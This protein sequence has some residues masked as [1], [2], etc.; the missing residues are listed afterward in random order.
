MFSR[1]PHARRALLLATTGGATAVLTS[2]P[3]PAFAAP[4][5]EIGDSDD[6]A[7]APAT[8]TPKYHVRA[9]PLFV[10]ALAHTSASPHHHP[11]AAN[12]TNTVLVVPGLLTANECDLLIAEADRLASL[13]LPSPECGSG[14]CGNC[15]GCLD[16]EDEEGEE[17]EEEGGDEG[18]DHLRRLSLCLM[19]PTAQQISRTVLRD[20]ILPLLQQQLPDVAAAL[21][22]R[23]LG[24]FKTLKGEEKGEEMGGRVDGRTA[25]EGAEEGGA[26]VGGA[27][28][29]EGA[30]TPSHPSPTTLSSTVAGSS[31]AGEAGEESEAGEK[32]EESEAAAVTAVRPW[33]PICGQRTTSVCAAL[34]AAVCA[35]GGPLAGIKGIQGQWSKWS[36]GG[37]GVRAEFATDEPTVNR[38]G[39]GG[40]FD[41][42]EDGYDLTVVI[43]L[44]DA[45]A[46]EG[47]GTAFYPQS[48]DAEEAAE[49]VETAETTD[50]RADA[51]ADN[52]DS[53]AATQGEQGGKGGLGGLG[54]TGGIGGIG[55]V[56]VQPTRGTALLFNG[57]LTHAGAS[58]IAGTR[59][60][61]VASFD[62]EH[63]NTESIDSSR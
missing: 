37:H 28:A 24:D 31:E 18:G 14:M 26:E 9:L 33:C 50:A 27:T 55:R 57:T 45:A 62:L 21:F 4:S 35:S 7:A 23:G 8:A 29:T 32:S 3:A 53:G 10:P 20:R 6:L 60:V 17:E 30:A 42:H 11:L 15:Q 2:Y 38:Y 58:V 51:A 22:R 25:E 48:V 1:V 43:L 56:V 49:A 46:F 13:P 41:K 59:H 16:G 52:A 19:S 36:M 54:G 39:P 47:G 61:Y 5:N 34:C 40:R 44:S 12:L 63:I